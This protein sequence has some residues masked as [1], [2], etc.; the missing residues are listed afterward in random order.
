M[1]V[2]EADSTEYWGARS[3]LD[4]LAAVLD[5]GA[6][7]GKNAQIHRMHR[8]ALHRALAGQRLGHILDFGCGT[9]RICAELAPLADRVTGVDIS[10]DMLDRARQLNPDSRIDFIAYDGKTLPFD[11]ASF[12][13]AVTVL[14]LQLYR[15]QPARFRSI[16]SELV[17]VLRPGAPAWLIEQAAPQFDGEAWSPHRWQTELARAGVDLLRLRPVRH[18]QHSPV[19]RAALSGVIPQRRLDSAAQL[20]MALTARMGMRGPYTECLMSVVRR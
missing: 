4:P 10:R 14:V 12:D 1:T 8:A 19:F 13:A 16:V 7:G 5:P 17:R 2:P 9:G 11:D 18:F 3:R 15:D 20:D 6:D